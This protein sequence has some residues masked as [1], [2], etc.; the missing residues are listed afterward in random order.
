MVGKAWWQEQK[1]VGHIV[2][3]VR[4]WGEMTAHFLGS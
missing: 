1:A 4:K 2:S 3:T